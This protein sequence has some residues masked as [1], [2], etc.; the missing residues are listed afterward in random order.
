MSDFDL[1][2]YGDKVFSVDQLL[3]KGYN[4]DI[5]RMIDMLV[6][7][8][9]G[10]TLSES[11]TN[12]F[13]GPNILTNTPM[14]KPNTNNNGYIF[15]TR[16]DLNLTDENIQVERRL[17][18]LLTGNGNS[19][20]RAIRLIL[21]PRLGVSFNLPGFSSNPVSRRGRL[22]CPLV[23]PNYPFIAVSD[24]SIKTLTGWPSGQLGVRESN[25][26][27]L[28]E[29]HIMA[30]GPS[31]YNGVYSLNLSTVSMRGNPVMYLYYFWILYI[32]FV[33]YQT[34]GVIPWPEYLYNGRMDYTCRIYRL[35]M[36]ESKTYVT[37]I[38]ATGYAIPRSVDI[39]PYF[40]Y[41]QEESRPFMSKTT[42]IEFTCVGAIYLDEILIQ[43]FN[44]TVMAYQPGMR[45]VAKSS[46]GQVVK[47][48]GGDMVVKGSFIKVPKR[49]Q[50]IF[51]N[52]CYPF[53]N[54]R[55]RELEWWIRADVY[56]AN[57]EMIKLADI[58]SGL[59]TGRTGK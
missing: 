12:T 29:V 13:K 59:Y 6:K 4:E 15:T 36:D 21:S 58:Q 55:T 26:G 24:N 16:P 8:K 10:F 7:S 56:N 34:Y 1:T 31:T 41:Q 44:S 23:D 47:G 33:Y 30:D 51:N 49:Y 32:G 52:L 5:S 50:N 43:Q 46:K 48:R 57:K 19:I 22:P 45:E 35:I 20:M 3:N 9:T 54:P 11:M 28:K 25:P 40:D 2:K 53:I 38:A 17:M 27:I 37:E 18:P 14:L 39:G 42:E